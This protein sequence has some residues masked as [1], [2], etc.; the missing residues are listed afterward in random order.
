[1]ERGKEPMRNPVMVGRRV[2]LRPVEPE[3][4]DAFAAALTNEPDT[5]FERG[6]FPISPLGVEHWIENTYKKQ[7]PDDI[8]LVVCLRQT[9][10]LIGSLNIDHLDWVNRTGETGIY[11]FGPYRNRGYGPEA[12]HLFLEYC[13]DR[14]QLHAI[15]SHVWEP[16]ARSAAA[17]KKQGYCPAGR[18]KWDDLKD[19]VYRDTLVFDLL[20][21]DWL[22]AREAWRAGRADAD[23]APESED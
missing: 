4:A 22:A 1:M 3:D 8:G 7:L 19:G 14:L 12:K 6:R 9:D 17:L 13:F 16:N 21:E 10:E 18:L 2:Y 20:R 5:Y 11:L 15:C 23:S